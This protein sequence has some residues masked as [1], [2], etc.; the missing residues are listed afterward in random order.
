MNKQQEKEIKAQ[1][2]DRFGIDK[3]VAKDVA[4]G[5]DVYRMQ[6]DFG[7]FSRYITLGLCAEKID[8]DFAE[9]FF[10]VDGC[11]D[12]E[13]E[14]VFL[15]DVGAMADQL[16]KGELTVKSGLTVKASEAAKSA[17]GFDYY[18]FSIYDYDFTRQDETIYVIMPI[19]IYEN[20]YA[21]IQKNGHK[22]FLELYDENVPEDEQL[23]FGT[24]RKPLEV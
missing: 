22:P 5:V 11:L 23:Y 13:K 20:E 2:D 16:R 19:Q 17:F 14:K 10:V 8:G 9:I 3:L 24:E 21:Y 15:A 4:P 18:L 1:Y 7:V 12:D 6:D